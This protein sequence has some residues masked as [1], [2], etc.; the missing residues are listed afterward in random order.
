MSDS[1]HGHIRNRILAA[2][3]EAGDDGLTDSELAIQLR[4]NK[5]HIPTRRRDV[6]LNGFCR[7]TGKT[8]Q[9]DTG[10]VAIVSVVTLEGRAF[11]AS[12]ATVPSRPKGDRSVPKNVIVQQLRGETLV[13]EFNAVVAQGAGGLLDI[14]PNKP[15]FV[16]AGDRFTVSLA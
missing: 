1:I 6:E 15:L 5:N 8:R 12:G 2:L 9:T 3:V 13:H 4:G 16:E 10:T 7:K 11:H 14:T